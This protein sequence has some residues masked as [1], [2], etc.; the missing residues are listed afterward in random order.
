MGNS[1]A[2]DVG[3]AAAGSTGGCLPNPHVAAP[4]PH[5]TASPSPLSLPHRG[6]H[7]MSPGPH[8]PYTIFP[9]CFVLSCS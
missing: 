1:N 8:N 6:G 4:G 7:V 9:S 3:A 2:G 5:C